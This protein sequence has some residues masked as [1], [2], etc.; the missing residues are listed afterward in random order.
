[1]AGVEAG[2]AR[3]QQAGGDDAAGVRVREGE[4]AEEGEEAGEVQREEGG[5]VEE[6]TLERE[7]GQ[8]GEAREYRVGQR[9]IPEEIRNFVFSGI[10][11]GGSCWRRVGDEEAEVADVCV[12][13][14][15]LGYQ[16]AAAQP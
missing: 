3:V 12:G 14:V 16:R 15:E 6:E 13:D 7:R 11:P 1:V 9:R 8:Q 2:Q 4:A 10:S 5:G